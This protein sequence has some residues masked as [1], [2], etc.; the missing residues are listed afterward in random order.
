MPRVYYPSF[1]LSRRGRV[2]LRMT[3][4]FIL[5][6][7]ELRG[8]IMWRGYILVFYSFSQQ[9]IISWLKWIEKR[10]AR[11]CCHNSGDESGWRL[12]NHSGP[13]KNRFQ[14]YNKGWIDMTWWVMNKRD[15]LCT[16]C[17]SDLWCLLSQVVSSS[18]DTLHLPLFCCRCPLSFYS[19]L[20][21]VLTLLI[22]HDVHFRQCPITP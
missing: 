15:L 4:Y 8:F 17:V 1:S 9:I 16:V 18:G 2:C 10:N 12:S 14:R 22:P 13:G 6:Q 20:K 5:W 11:A 7:F 3:L 21:N 19:S